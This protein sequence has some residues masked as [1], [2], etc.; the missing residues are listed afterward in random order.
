[1]KV[2]MSFDSGYVSHNSPETEITCEIVCLW[3]RINKKS[4]MTLIVILFSINLLNNMIGRPNCHW[5]WNIVTCI[6]LKYPRLKDHP[7][8][9]YQRVRVSS[10]KVV[11][12]V[13][14]LKY[15]NSTASGRVISPEP[16]SLLLQM[17]ITILLGSGLCNHLHNVGA[18]ITVH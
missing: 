7:R 8:E 12:M 9:G 5:I 11:S 14:F 10:F 16:N 18:V 15:W 17:I 4:M 13:F 6:S 2:P 3:Q 1:M